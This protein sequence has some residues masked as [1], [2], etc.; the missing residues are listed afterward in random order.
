MEGSSLEF[1]W[2]KLEFSGAN[3]ISNRD[4][5]YVHGEFGVAEATPLPGYFDKEIECLIG[6]ID[7]V[8]KPWPKPKRESV[9]VN[10]LV[11]CKDDINENLLNFGSVKVKVH[12]VNDCE[13]V[14]QVREFVGQTVKIRIDCNGKFDVDQALIVM[15]ALRDTELELIEQPLKFSQAEEYIKL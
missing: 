12:S 14:K 8:S 7:T 11:S 1:E 10:A 4:G 9:D 13:M 3:S 6:A 2:V 15:R 5:L